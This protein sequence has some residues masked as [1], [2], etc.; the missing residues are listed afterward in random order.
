MVKMVNFVIFVCMLCVLLYVFAIFVI[1]GKKRELGLL[2]RSN[3]MP[4]SIEGGSYQAFDE[5]L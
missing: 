2:S 4:T 5:C 1:P 3:N